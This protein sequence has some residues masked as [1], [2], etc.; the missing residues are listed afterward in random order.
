MEHNPSCELAVMIGTRIG[1]VTDAELVNASKAL[2]F[3]AIKEVDQP[4]VPFAIIQCSC[5][6]DHGR[7]WTTLL[8]RTHDA[9]RQATK[10]VSQSIGLRHTPALS[11]KFL[12][13]HVFSTDSDHE[14]PCLRK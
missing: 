11:V 3:P 4:S 8:P 13:L 7:L 5:K 14:Y 12:K 10:L 6:G 2:K 9:I 1:K